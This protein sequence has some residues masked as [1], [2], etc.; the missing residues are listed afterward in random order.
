MKHLERFSDRR[1]EAA[2]LRS[3]KGEEKYEDTPQP[4]KGEFFR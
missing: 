4:P 2:Y 1:K 3:L